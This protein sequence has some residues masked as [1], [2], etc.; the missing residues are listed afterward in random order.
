M[1]D[2]AYPSLDVRV[3]SHRIRLSIDTGYNAR[4]PIEGVSGLLILKSA[5]ETTRGWRYLDSL[6]MKPFA[7][8]QF[9]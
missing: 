1:G 2:T 7:I 4:L 5:A 8:S 6:A 3:N 9:T